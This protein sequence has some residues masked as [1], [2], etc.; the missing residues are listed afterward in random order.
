MLSVPGASAI[1]KGGLTLYTLESRMA[2]G[3]WTEKD[4]KSYSGP[5]REIVGGLAE[6]VRVKLE[7]TYSVAESG[8]AGPSGGKKIP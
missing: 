7:A 1:F 4:V 2:F 8:S 5:T 3:G 6:N